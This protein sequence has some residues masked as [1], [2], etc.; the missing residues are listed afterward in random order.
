MASAVLRILVRAL[1]RTLR[2]RSPGAGPGAQFGAVTFLHRFGSSLNS[3]FHYHLC[4]LD[5]VFE[6]VERE[7]ADGTA[8]TRVRFHEA[9]DL[10]RADVE[11]LQESVRRRVLRWFERNGLLEDHVVDEMLGWGHGGG[12]SLDASVRIAGHDRVGLERLIR[13][14]ARP[15]FALERLE[16]R[17]SEDDPS[18]E[19]VVLYHLA[20]PAHDGRTV[21]RLSPLELL[22]RLAT[23]LP[24]P[25]VHRHRYHGVLAPNAALRPLVTPTAPA[26]RSGR[27]AARRGS[28]RWARLLARIYHARPLVCPTCGRTMRLIAFLTDPFSIRDVL[29]H[30]DEPTRPPRVHRPRGPPEPTPELVIDP[31][32]SA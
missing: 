7:G 32:V 12:F 24:P 13:Y 16:W 9:T 10:N 5:G 19:G 28:V 21:V 29:A 22:D 11:A 31:V 18:G 8:L 4:V 17:G 2:E 30:L 14:C 6:G 26:A 27:S 15:P 20:R 1:R 25:R 3:H 23:L